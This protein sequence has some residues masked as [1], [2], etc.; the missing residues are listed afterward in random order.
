MMIRRYRADGNYAGLSITRSRRLIHITGDLFSIRRMNNFIQVHLLWVCLCVWW[1]LSDRQYRRQMLVRYNW[2]NMR[3]YSDFIV[4]D[5]GFLIW[6]G[7]RF[8]YSEL[9]L[10]YVFDKA[11]SDL[12][13]NAMDHIS[14]HQ[15]LHARYYRFRRWLQALKSF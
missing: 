11:D 14:M 5:Y 7:E 1:P 6:F 10:L 2:S 3:L 12:C 9:L 15:S 13:L 8:G 4:T